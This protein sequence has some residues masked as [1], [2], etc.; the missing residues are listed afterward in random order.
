MIE[1]LDE[2][3]ETCWIV[4]QETGGRIEGSLTPLEWIAHAC[5][6][7]VP[8]VLASPL[9]RPRRDRASECEII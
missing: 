6:G 7:L 5:G 9:P 3:A 1:C 2:I 4:S 8:A